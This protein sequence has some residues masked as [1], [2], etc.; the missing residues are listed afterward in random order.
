MTGQEEERQPRDHD[1]DRQHRGIYG[2]GEK[3]VGDPL[4]VA[5]DPA[6]LGNDAG[7][8]REPAVEQ[9]ELGDPAAGVAAVAHCDADVG[10]LEGK[11]VVD[12]VPRH[13]DV[14]AAALQRRDQSLLLLGAHTAEDRVLLT[15]H[16]EVPRVGGKVAGV[17]RIVGV[18]QVQPTGDRPDRDGVVA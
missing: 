1:G 15:D 17:D 6:A 10:V 14:M 4:D 9:D 8:D 16:F 5:D 2:L 3:E 7:N 18:R 13:G 12:P 11:H